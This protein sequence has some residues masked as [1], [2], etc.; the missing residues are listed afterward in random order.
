MDPP[1][2]EEDFMLLGAVPVPEPVADVLKVIAADFQFLHLID[3]GEEV[4]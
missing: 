4:G 3:H 1:A 2:V